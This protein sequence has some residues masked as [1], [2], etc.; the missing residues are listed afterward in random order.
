[1]KKINMINLVLVMMNVWINVV[2]L[3]EVINHGVALN[4][5]EI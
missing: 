5:Q 4:L 3:L 1:M 2:E